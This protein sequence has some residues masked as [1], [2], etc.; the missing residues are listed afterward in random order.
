MTT[1]V[2]I[3]TPYAAPTASQIEDNIAVAIRLCQIARRMGHLPIAPHIY[4]TK[5][6]DDKVAVDRTWG[7]LQG[8][9]LLRFC[10][11][12]YAIKESIDGI[13]SP[14]VREEVRMAEMLEIPVVE[15]SIE[16]RSEEPGFSLWQ[17]GG[18]RYRTIE[19]KE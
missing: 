9:W 13:V 7:M 17:R 3:A 4:F 14:G 19:E 1:L 16:R 5:F 18:I 11:T 15:W 12:V 6:L 2:Y 8:K 10:E